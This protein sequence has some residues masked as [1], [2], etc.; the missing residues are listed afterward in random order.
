MTLILGIY[1]N[2]HAMQVSDRLV[3]A[4]I[5]TSTPVP[6][7]TVS[8]KTVVLYAR[9]GIVSISYTGPAY[10]RGKP[11]DQ[12][13]AE[14]VSGVK[15]DEH[16]GIR[17]GRNICQAHDVGQAIEELRTRAG[18][19]FAGRA[20]VPL[21]EFHVIGSQWDRRKRRLRPVICKVTNK[22]TGTAEFEK[23][24]TPREWVPVGGKWTNLLAGTGTEEA[25]NFMRRRFEAA[26]GLQ[27]PEHC[28][29]VMCEAIRHVSQS[30]P[31]LVGPDCMAV[32]VKGSSPMVTISYKPTGEHRIERRPNEPP[33]GPIAFTPFVVAPDMVS[34]PAISLNNM[35]MATPDLDIRFEGWPQLPLSQLPAVQ[36]HQPRPRRP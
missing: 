9:R 14:T 28:V 23:L 27:S 15:L 13:V 29:D 25:R 32:V 30:V 2:W 19:A 31:N 3:S 24:V 8:N 22:R 26:G 6:F 1:T 35:F 34:P 33:M 17:L 11:T 5:G 7:D 10:V 20:R 21:L 18:I 36:V 12:W 16:P 4:Q